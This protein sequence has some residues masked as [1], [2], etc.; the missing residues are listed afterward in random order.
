VGFP[1]LSADPSLDVFRGEI[2][3][4]RTHPWLQVARQITQLDSAIFEMGAT[5]ACRIIHPALDFGGSRSGQRQSTNSRHACRDAD[6]E[7]SRR[8]QVRSAPPDNLPAARITIAGHG[9]GRQ[10]CA[11]PTRKTRRHRYWH[12]VSHRWWAPLWTASQPWARRG[13]HVVPVRFVC[14]SQPACGPVG[15]TCLAQH[16]VVQILDMARLAGTADRITTY[17]LCGTH[18]GAALIPSLQVS[19]PVDVLLF[20]LCIRS[21]HCA[22]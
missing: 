18:A 7:Q 1:L 8:W 17:C 20:K 22:P 16:A 9:G 15:A 21:R 4:A 10:S 12:S 6:P 5:L 13:D 11:Q 3:V 19:P 14:H 2:T